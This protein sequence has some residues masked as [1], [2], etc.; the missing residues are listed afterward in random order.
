MCIRDRN[1]NVIERNELTRGKLWLPGYPVEYEL[2]VLNSR[3]RV[4]N[5]NVNWFSILAALN[6]PAIAFCLMDVRLTLDMNLKGITVF[7]L[8]LDVQRF[9]VLL[10]K[11]NRDRLTVLL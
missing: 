8:Q 4:V 5:D 7:L 11:A 1:L 2:V 6:V 10:L 9:A 3:G